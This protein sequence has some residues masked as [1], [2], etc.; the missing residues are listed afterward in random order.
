M[1]ASILVRH[2]SEAGIELRLA[3]G[4]VKVRGRAA[5]VA[6]LAPELRE[7]RL[8]LIEFLSAAH[9]STTAL[10]EAAM[11]A[12]DNFG[13]DVE[14]HVVVAEVRVL[15]DRAPAT[16]V[17]PSHRAQ[18]HRMTSHHRSSSYQQVAVAGSIGAGCCEVDSPGAE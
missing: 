2:A 13:D 6:A 18:R 5:A 17:G 7:H 3:D 16:D 11:R 8:E 15:V 1:N 12:C 9:E 4:K 14:A 10:I